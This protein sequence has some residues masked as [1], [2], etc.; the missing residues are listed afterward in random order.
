MAMT[1]RPAGTMSGT[2]HVR[3]AGQDCMRLVTERSPNPTNAPPQRRGAQRVLHWVWRRLIVHPFRQ[4][5]MTE[6]PAF[7]KFFSERCTHL[8]GMIAYFGLLSLIP[9]TFLLF[10]ML[11]WTGEL[12]Q[13]GWVIRQL[14]YIMPSQAVTFILDNVDYLRRTSNSLGVIGLFGVIFAASNFFSC[15]ESALNI[16]YGVNNRYFLKQKLLVLVLMGFAMALMAGSMVA[17][18]LVYPL[19]TIAGHAFRLSSTETIISFAISAFGAFLFFLSCYRFLPNTEIH[20]KEVW[21][22]ALGAALAFEISI[23]VLPMYLASSGDS[24]IVKAFAGTLIVLVWFYLN[25]FILLAGAVFN[26]YW[27]RRSVFQRLA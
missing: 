13:Q 20:T 23:H 2:G 6:H 4:V 9:A 27:A 19:L 26:W 17:V 11:S 10:S 18:S 8:A 1:C 21:R 5:V 24:I 3:T 25:A 7:E 14:R 22:G 16:I 15:I 12:S